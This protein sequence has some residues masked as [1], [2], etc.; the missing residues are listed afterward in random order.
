[1]LSTRRCWR[2][3]R[4]YRGYDCFWWIRQI[5][6]RGAEYDTFFP[7]V[8]QLPSPRRGSL[9]CPI[10]GPS[11]GHDA[12]LRQMGLDGIRWRAGCRHGQPSR[13]LRAGPPASLQFADEVFDEKVRPLMDK[14]PSAS[15]SQR[16]RTTAPAAD[17][18]RAD[19]L[20]LAAAGISTVL[21][22][23]GYAPDGWLKVPILDDFGVPRHV[24]GVSGSGP[25]FLGVLFQHD[26]RS[27]S[28]AGVARDAG[29]SPRGCEFRRPKPSYASQVCAATSEGGGAADRALMARFM[30]GG[31]GPTIEAP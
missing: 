6:D 23:T 4:R 24:R 8:A 20:D 13:T 3:P 12:N 29:S 31:I 10:V 26:N 17:D 27:A 5:I 22:T 11:G 15:G 2:I 18:R 30:P 19:R 9:Q 16:S 14:A 21:W 28:L 7:T 1:M 25:L